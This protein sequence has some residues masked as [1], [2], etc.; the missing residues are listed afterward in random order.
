MK[1]KKEFTSWDMFIIGLN[2]FVLGMTLFRITSGSGGHTSA[3]VA[4]ASFNILLS[5]IS[6][7]I[8][9]LWMI[10]IVG[11]SIHTYMKNRKSGLSVWLSVKRYTWAYLLLEIPLV[12][13]YQLAING[14][15]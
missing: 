9:V 8:A 14:R 15:M 13:A 1:M 11:M 6:S 2:M 3:V 4:L 12:F 10:A 7:W 5:R